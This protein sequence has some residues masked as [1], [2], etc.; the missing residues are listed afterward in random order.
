MWA[1]LWDVNFAA[2]VFWGRGAPK[3]PAARPP[4][5]FA[6]YHF[7]IGLL[8]ETPFLLTTHSKFSVLNFKLGVQTYYP[9]SWMFFFHT[10]ATVFPTSCQMKT[11]CSCR[12]SKLRCMSTEPCSPVPTQS[13]QS[14]CVRKEALGLMLMSI[15]PMIRCYIIGNVQMCSKAFYFSK[16]G[17]GYIGNSAISL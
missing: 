11:V 17:L 2:V 8:Y 3:T 15:M 1:S 10:L 12:V 16:V 14:L 6:I 5:Y 13:D 4:P 9:L 7:Y